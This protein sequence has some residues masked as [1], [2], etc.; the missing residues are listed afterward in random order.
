MCVCVC[1]C[2]VKEMIPNQFIKVIPK[3]EPCWCPLALLFA[4]SSLVFLLYIKF[5]DKGPR[6][7]QIGKIEDGILEFN[8]LTIFFSFISCPPLAHIMGARYALG[9]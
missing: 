5:Q 1:V 2:Y 8:T 6:S 4:P 7:V 3:V 9:G